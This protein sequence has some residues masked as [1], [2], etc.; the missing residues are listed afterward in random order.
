MAAAVHRAAETAH[1]ASPRAK[2]AL[3]A[4]GSNDA[5]F[6]HSRAWRSP[7]YVQSGPW[8]NKARIEL[9]TRSM[10]LSR[11]STVSPLVGMGSPILTLTRTGRTMAPLPHRGAAAL[12][13]HRDDG[14]L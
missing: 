8:S 14:D 13:R 2:R 3:S 6:G 9:R 7:V 4:Q 10:R 1:R 12:D 11:S 5:W